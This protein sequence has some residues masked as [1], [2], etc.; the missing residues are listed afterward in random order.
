[1]IT[2]KTIVTVFGVAVLL[3]SGY[4]LGYN[5]GGKCTCPGKYTCPGMTQQAPSK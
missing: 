4:F 1:M 2:K 5:F 3:L